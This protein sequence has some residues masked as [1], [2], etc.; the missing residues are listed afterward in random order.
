M[1]QSFLSWGR[2]DWG[3]VSIKALTLFL[4]QVIWMK[5]LRQIQK[6]RRLATELGFEII[7]KPLPLSY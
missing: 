5:L 2:L 4:P 7:V 3:E 6:N 1:S